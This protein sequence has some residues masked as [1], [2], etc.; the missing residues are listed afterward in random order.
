MARKRISAPLEQKILYESRWVCAVCQAS[1][2]QIH[3]IDGD[4]SNNVEENLIVLCTK[5]HDEA[6]TKRTM[7]K[8][9]D[10]SALRHAKDAW[11]A[12]VKSTRE[13]TASVSGQLALTN[14]SPLA[15]FGI[16]WGY[17]NHSRVIHMISLDALTGRDADLL[18]LCIDRGIVDP[19]GIPILDANTP[20]AGSYIGNAIYDRLPHGDDQ[21]LHKLYVAMV[22][23]LSRTHHPLHL[24]RECWTKEQILGLL[25]AGSLIFVQGAFNFRSVSETTTN[26]HRRVSLNQRG[27]SIEFFVD[28]KDMFGTTS[29]TISFSGHQT[30]AAFLQVK[31]LDKTAGL[32]LRCTPIALGVAFNKRWV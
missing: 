3:H 10:S 28:S 30:C 32:M 4:P 31:S 29:M 5:H 8:N 12:N 1:G 6:H 24:E 15:S 13:S 17:I 11:I 20:A 2:C 22:D 26:D 16:T 25:Q 9:L 18:S 19:H 14:G 21:R 23:Q 27:V 7:S